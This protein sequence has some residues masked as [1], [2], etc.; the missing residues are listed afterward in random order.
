MSEQFNT[1]D[2]MIERIAVALWHRFAPDYS[3][4]WENETHAAEYRDAARAV[5][6]IVN[7]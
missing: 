6:E 3:L 5:L 4:E 7:G 2:D 1:T